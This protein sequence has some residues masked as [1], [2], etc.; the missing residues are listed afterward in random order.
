MIL[1][2]PVEL[3]GSSAAVRLS[4]DDLDAVL[5][6]HASDP[7]RSFFLPMMLESY[8]F[9]GIWEAGRLVASAGTHVASRGHGVAAVGAV[10]TRPSH[11]GHGLGGLAMSA[12]CQTLAKEYRTVGLNVEAGN[13]PALR[14]YDRLGFRRVFQY[15]EV[16][17]L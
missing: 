4:I 16:E 13:E 17:L 12:L 6:L 3:A 2:Q 14:I 10:I 5:D 8:P 9:V 15:E 11:R 7:D 1:S